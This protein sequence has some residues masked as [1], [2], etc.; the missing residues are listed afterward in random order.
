MSWQ[1]ELRRLDAELAKGTISL[2]DHRRLRDELLAAASGRFEPAPVAAPRRRTGSPRPPEP[3][4]RNASAALLA[5]QRPTTATSP[6]DERA[7]ERM[8]HPRITEAPTVVTQAIG[9]L[10]PLT[11]PPDSERVPPLPTVPVRP[12]ERRRTWL[13]VAGAVVLTV[14]LIV[15]AS[16]LLLNRDTPAPSTASPAPGPTVAAPTPLAQRLPALPG[17]ANADSGTVPVA[18]G[19]RRGLY[20]AEAAQE[21]ARNGATEIEYRAST[22]G[23]R[24]Y[25]LLAVPATSPAAARTVAGYMRDGAL[26]TGFTPLPDDSSVVTGVQN[27]RTMNGTWYSS[28]NVAIIFWVSQPANARQATELKQA[29]D[30][31]R[32]ALQQALPAR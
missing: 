30:Q 11:P 20:P 26:S 7:T 9:P 8:P 19:P 29:L 1:D 28:D 32:S 12:S 13:F 27:G 3:E 21:F 24:L 6:A 18:D 2:H 4:P 5:S 14:V 15:I 10:P 17:T 31:T 25:F 23:T 16:V 22:S